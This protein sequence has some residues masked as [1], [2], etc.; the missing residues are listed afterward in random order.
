MSLRTWFWVGPTNVPPRSETSPPPSWW[1]QM[2]PPTRSRASTTSTDLPAW[3]I[4]RAAV[5]PAMPA[6]TTMKSAVM[7]FGVVLLRFFFGAGLRF[8]LAAS[9]LG[10][11][12]SRAA[13]APA[14]TRRRR[15]KPSLL[16]TLSLF[17][18]VGGDPVEVGTQDGLRLV[19][20][21][22]FAGVFAP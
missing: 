6:P 10:T 16:T 18:V 14:P 13:P 9:A 17:G 4:S 22:R 19:E 21:R 2:R 3:M 20:K 1:F 12:P 8:F 15:V 11:T 7:V 5:R